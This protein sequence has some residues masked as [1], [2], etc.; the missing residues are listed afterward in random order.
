MHRKRRPYLLFFSLPLLFSVCPAA[1]QPWTLGILTTNSL[2]DPTCPTGFNCHGF[3]V[4]CPGVS[5]AIQGFW[6]I[7]PHQGA[8]RGFVLFFT[9]GDGTGWW[10]EQDANLPAM[11]AELRSL[12]FT[13][14]QA[15][16]ASSWLESSP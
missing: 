3:S 7:A 10:S 12:G 1:G 13:V 15:R 9:G 2:T 11:V 4:M 6:A 8:A 14:A 5:N 16:W